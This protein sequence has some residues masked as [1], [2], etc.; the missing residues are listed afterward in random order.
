MFTALYDPGGASVADIF[1]EIDEEL[2]RDRFEQV[3]RQHGRLIIGLAAAA[4]VAAAAYAGWQKYQQNRSIELSDRYAAAVTAAIPETGDPARA[5]ESFA[6]LAGEG[7]SYA[8]LAQLE[9][10]ALAAKRDP[11]AAAALYDQLAA[12]G[13]VSPEL[14]D[15]ARLLKVMLLVD[16]G[17]PATLSGELQPLSADDN[18]WRFSAREL[19]A[20][21]A[22]RSGDQARATEL[23]TKLSDEAATP[24][25]IRMRA[26][27]LLAALKG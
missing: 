23:L 6:A 24:G 26:S 3:W 27:E 16:S 1:K 2:R 12:D 18:P 5:E 20:L 4:V 7:S 8:G 22:L 9:A 19:D 13:G 21:L 17:D 10:A 15:L 25:P 11:Q 14:R